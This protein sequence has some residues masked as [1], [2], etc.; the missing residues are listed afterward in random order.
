MKKPKKAAPTSYRIPEKARL[1]LLDLHQKHKTAEANS[2]LAQRSVV[3]AL[4]LDPDHDD[5]N[6]N[7][8]T[9]VVTVTPKQ[10]G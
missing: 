8:D 3:A 9:G 7:L 2:N 6:L 5:I 1:G 4:G 10:E